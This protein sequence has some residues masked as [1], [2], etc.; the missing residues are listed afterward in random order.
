[1]RLLVAEDDNPLA[2]SVRKGLEAEN[3]AVDI[4]SNGEEARTLAEEHE[5]DLIIF[6]LNLPR[7]DGAEVLKDLRAKKRL[8]PVIAFTDRGEAG[9]RVLGPDLGADDYL[10]KP[11]SLSELSARVHALLRRGSRPGKAVLRVEDLELDRTQRVV[12]RAGQRIALTPKEFAL[13]EFL[14]RNAGRQVTRAMIIEHVW[15]LSLDT[16][17]NVVDVYINY[18][19]KKIDERSTRKLI[20]TVRGIGYQL[21]GKEEDAA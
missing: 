8:L 16:M 20:R 15:N 3:Y 5:Y 12:K 2:V 4:A 7:V 21:G 10:D 9:N 18:L 11:F 17:T 1:M 6:D 13:L 19:R 14:M